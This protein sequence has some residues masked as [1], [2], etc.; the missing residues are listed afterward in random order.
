MAWNHF[1]SRK[2]FN[3]LQTLGA[4]EPGGAVVSES[5][6]HCIGTSD[7]PSRMVSSKPPLRYTISP[8]LDDVT[9]ITDEQER[10]SFGHVDLHAYEAVCMSRKMMKRDALAEVHHPLV[11]SLPIAGG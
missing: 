8:I 7:S 2:T 6:R 11:E 1:A 5:P 3:V 9:M 4:A 10:P